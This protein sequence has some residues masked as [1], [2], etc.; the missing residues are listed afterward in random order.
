VQGASERTPLPSAFQ[1]PTPLP[2]KTPGLVTP[3][4][5][6]TPDLD[7]SRIQA[8]FTAGKALRA[9]S[10]ADA[11]DVVARIGRIPVERR[12][13]TYAA[14]LSA[15]TGGGKDARAIL[16]D[17]RIPLAIE[18]E[19]VA[20]GFTPSSAEL[21]SFIAGQRAKLHRDAQGAS[22]FAAFLSGLGMTEDEYYAL[23]DVMQ[24]LS[25]QWGADK[26]FES[27]TAA[28]PVENR[29]A[30]WRE[31]SRALAAKV[32]VTILDPALK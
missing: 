16:Q 3:I 20:R 21:A 14:I 19:A 2:P 13:L 29:A 1:F 26:L 22:E 9:D 15:R 7:S 5:Q 4:P 31:F 17:L 32:T 8:W 12:H 30:A 25:Y 18:D 6:R 28:V 11:T 27:V 10:S 24:D 23:P